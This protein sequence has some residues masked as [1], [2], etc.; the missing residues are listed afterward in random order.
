M[1]K[2]DKKRLK[3]DKMDYVRRRIG[4]A[5]QKGYEMKRL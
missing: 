1:M 3:V 2:E 4:I 5:R